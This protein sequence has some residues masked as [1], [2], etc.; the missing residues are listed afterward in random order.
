SLFFTIGPDKRTRSVLAETLQLAERLDDTVAQMQTL[1]VITGLQ[2]NAG[3]S[4][5]GQA[6]AEQFVRVAERTGEPST[7]IFAQ[8]L[9]ANALT[10]R[11]L[12]A[13]AR[14]RLEAVLEAVA[15]G[16]TPPERL[17]RSMLMFRDVG[18]AGR[19]ILARVLGLQG[20]VDT[21]ARQAAA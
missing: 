12:H 4:F 17:L 1:W 21:G 20:L 14:T 6:S 16:L 18:L 19:L 3:E 8:R 7:V 10:F 15:K 11:G 13:Q 9:L 5:A 2:L